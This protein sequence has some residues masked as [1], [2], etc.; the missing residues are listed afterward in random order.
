METDFKNAWETY[1][2]PKRSTLSAAQ[3]T[4]YEKF[5]LSNRER[6]KR[7]IEHVQS[8][9]FLD[10]KGKRVLDI[11]SAYGGFVICCAHMGAKAYGIEILDYLHELAKANALNEN[12]H[13]K[14]IKKDVLDKSVL[15]DTDNQPF[16]LIIINDVFEHIYNSYAF[17]Y[18]IKEFSGD[19]TIIYFEIPNGESWQ[20]IEKEGHKFLFGLTLLE[21]GAWPK[22]LGA[23]NI[24][25]RPFEYYHL[26]FNHIGFPH[27][28]L[29][30]DKNLIE[31]SQERVT[32]KFTEL[33]K[34]INDGPFES[35]FL[36]EHA[37]HKFELLKQKLTDV[38][39]EECPL[40]LHLFYDQF[41]WR[42]YAAR[43]II[44]NLENTYDLIRITF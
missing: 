37:R 19:D 34:K 16:D 1:F 39:G 8:R 5:A 35:N 38:L 11:G 30:V 36:N 31:K 9:L 22:E 24:Y 33:E 29:M 2:A 12:G 40:K 28:Y 10:F 32:N 15:N 6:A 17:F 20:G 23:F 18:R 42:G 13:I 14:L 26:H 3:V 7:F 27:L 21:P 44:P 4:A 25:Y 43:E 41:F